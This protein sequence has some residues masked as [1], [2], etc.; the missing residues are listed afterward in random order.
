MKI[1]NRLKY[2]NAIT[3]LIQEK[4]YLLFKLRKFY[5][6]VINENEFYWLDIQNEIVKGEKA[7]K[8]TE[9]LEEEDLKLILLKK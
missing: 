7:K 1:V 4:K 9:L 5:T 3:F 8:L 6:L 2:G